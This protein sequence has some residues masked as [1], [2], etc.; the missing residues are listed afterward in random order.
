MV[1]YES[2]QNL[3][4]LKYVTAKKRKTKPNQ[5]TILCSYVIP[6]RKDVYLLS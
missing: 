1:N 3:K 4:T 5:S 2:T 6:E